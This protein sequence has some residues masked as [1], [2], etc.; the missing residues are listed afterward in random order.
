[1]EKNF[2]YSDYPDSSIYKKSIIARIDLTHQLISYATDLIQISVTP[3]YNNIKKVLNLL[4]NF[5]IVTRVTVSG[6]RSF[7]ISGDKRE[8]Y[9]RY[10]I[11][12]CK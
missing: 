1:M 3:D 8:E 6:F 7:Y 10:F 9:S 11:N 12:T 5:E 4:L 2:G